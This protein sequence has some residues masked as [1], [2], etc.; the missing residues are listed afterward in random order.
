M[1]NSNTSASDNASFFASVD[2]NCTITSKQTDFSWIKERRPARVYFAGK[3]KHGGG[4]RRSLLQNGRVMSE[5]VHKGKVKGYPVIYTGPFALSCDHGCAHFDGTH[6]WNNNGCGGS[7]GIH[8][9]PAGERYLTATEL[10][11]RC[12]QQ[13]ANSDAIHAYID[14]ADCHGT[15]AELGYAAGIQKPIFLVFSEDFDTERQYLELVETDCEHMGSHIRDD[16]WFVRNLPGVQS[17]FYGNEATIDPILLGI[18]EAQIITEGSKSKPLPDSGQWIYFI[19]SQGFVKIGITGN[20]NSRLAQLQ[21]ASA[22]VLELLAV[23]PGSRA[24]EAMLHRKF[25]HLRA[26]GEWFRLEGT[27][28]QYLQALLFVEDL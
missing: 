21:T 1:T 7:D 25:A 13:I 8:D 11:N 16:F 19:R 10:V 5:G 12:F 14:S 27:L 20:V 2:R 26:S 6:G 22:H 18:N 9:Y 17:V 15:L 23:I 3:V 4:Y 24:K 28:Q